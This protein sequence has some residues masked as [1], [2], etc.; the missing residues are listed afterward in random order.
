MSRPLPFSVGGAAP[1]FQ[2]EVRVAVARPGTAAVGAAW[3]PTAHAIASMWTPRP[4]RE[5]PANESNSGRRVM[6]PA[7]NHVAAGLLTTAEGAVRLRLGSA[8]PVRATDLT[9]TVLDGES[10][11]IVDWLRSAVLEDGARP[12]CI[13]YRSRPTLGGVHVFWL[14]AVDVG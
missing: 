1:P 6:A 7:L 12:H 8:R 3:R 10:V 4:V 9:L 2:E 14:L 11:D 13:V 5:P